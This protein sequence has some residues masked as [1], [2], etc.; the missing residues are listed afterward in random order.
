MVHV[1]MQQNVYMWPG[2]QCSQSSPGLYILL[3]WQL[4]FG[5]VQ[6]WKPQSA[7]MNEYRTLHFDLNLSSTI[8]EVMISALSDPFIPN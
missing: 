5:A 8:T 3:S 2:I 7:C 6:T 4:I 1:Y